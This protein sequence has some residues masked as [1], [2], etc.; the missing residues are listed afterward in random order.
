MS[1]NPS[2]R[3][4]SL[5]IIIAQVM[6]D[7]TYE[8]I[9]KYKTL[10]KDIDTETYVDYISIDIITR[11]NNNFMRHEIDRITKIMPREF[12][13]TFIEI[14]SGIKE[15]SLNE[16]LC[17]WKDIHTLVINETLSFVCLCDVIDETYKY[18]LS[19]LSR[20]NVRDI[21]QDVLNKLFKF[22]RYHTSD[23]RVVKGYLD[24]LV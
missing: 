7:I 16:D 18:T 14:E 24:I 5:A 23:S 9:S 2:N 13:I 12:L 15:K 21:N 19:I 1:T 10:I 11:C 3:E 6:S 22:L 8:F 20:E 4:K 17:R